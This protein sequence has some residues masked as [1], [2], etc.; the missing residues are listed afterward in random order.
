VTRTLHDLGE[1]EVHH[2]DEVAAR[3][4]GL[5]NDVLRLEIAVHDTDVMRFGERGERLTQDIE[6]TANGQRSLFVGD[7]RQIAPA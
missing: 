4:Q 5:E 6:D 1:S 3:A 2:L 7:A